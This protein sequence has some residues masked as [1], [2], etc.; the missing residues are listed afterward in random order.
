MIVRLKR[1]TS[2]EVLK[3]LNIYKYSRSINAVDRKEASMV[4]QRAVGRSNCMEL[5]K[6]VFGL[7][8]SKTFGTGMCNQNP[9]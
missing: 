8:V 2:K 3:E 5:T 6:G 4:L 1:F 9:L 7:S